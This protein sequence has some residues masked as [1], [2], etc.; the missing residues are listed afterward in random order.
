MGVVYLPLGILNPGIPTPPPW[1]LTPSGIPTPRRNLGPDTPNP[2]PIQKGPGTRDTYSPPVDR[3][4]DRRLWKH[5]LPVTTLQDC[6]NSSNNVNGPVK[7]TVVIG[8]THLLPNR[9]KQ[10]FMFFESLLKIA[11]MADQ[12]D[13]HPEQEAEYRY[14]WGRLLM[15]W[16]IQV[17]KH[18]C[19]NKLIHVNY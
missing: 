2:P 6:N 3:M 7:F 15:I 8:N 14:L 1:Y 11:K 18:P 10:R 17:K 5:Y 13:S 9:F 12:M 19:R 4:I 16:D